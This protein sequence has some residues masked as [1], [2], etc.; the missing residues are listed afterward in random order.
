MLLYVL[1]LPLLWFGIKAGW[2]KANTDFPNY[3]VSAQ[4]LIK[5]HLADAYDVALFNTAIHEYNSEASGLFVMYPPTTSLLALGLT[6]FDL[7]NAKRIW[8]LIS[9]IAIVGIVFLL[10][11]IC[12]IDKTSASV[13]LLLSGFSLYNDLMLGQVYLVMLA[14]I[15][16]GWHALVQNK[17]ILS[18][19]SWGFVAAFKF[20]PLFFIPFLLFKKQYKITFFLLLSFMVIHLFTLVIGGTDAYNSFFQVFIDNYLHGKVANQTA[21]SIQYQSMEALANLLSQLSHWPNWS[22]NLLKIIW[23]VIWLCFVILLWLKYF[24]S[25]YFLIVSLTSVTLIL[26]LFENGSASYHLL[27]CLFAS[28]AFLQIVKDKCWKITLFLAYATIGFIPVLISL[29]HIDNL[30]V[31]FSRLWCL[32]LFAAIF[33]IGLLKQPNFTK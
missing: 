32:S 13:I 17:A 23:K 2:N 31:N 18:G 5:G 21:L 10:K 33:F 14:F 27:F 1:L 15:I 22:V 26:L 24:N 16:L 29:L 4:L 20:L 11:S 25:K 30:F 12:N 28:M 6:S 8:I 19:M 7:L 3:Y 9:L